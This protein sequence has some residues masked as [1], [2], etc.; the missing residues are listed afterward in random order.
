MI[1][2]QHQRQ[3]MK[4][5]HLMEER[6]ISQQSVADALNI[7]RAAVNQAVHGKTRSLRIRAMISNLLNRPISDLWKE[8]NGGS[9]CNKNEH[10]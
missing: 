5:R 9:E 10:T 7:T 3:A 2:T 4:I 1:Y 6:G 8:D